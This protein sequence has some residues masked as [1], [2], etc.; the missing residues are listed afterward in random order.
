[1]VSWRGLKL[2][3]NEEAYGWFVPRPDQPDRFDQQASFFHSQS[4]GVAWMVG[5]NGAGTTNISLA[6]MVRFLMETPPPRYDTPFWV[7]SDT[8]EVVCESCWKEKLF[9]QGL[10]PRSEID[11]E[12]IHWYKSTRGWPFAVPL[13]PYRD[14]PNKNWVIEFKSYKQGRS[15]MQARSIGGFLFV[16]QFPWDLLTEVLRGCREYNYPGS[17]LCEFTPINPDLSVHLQEML[18]EDTLPRGWEVFRANTECAMEA[19]HV[20]KEW[21]EEF[22][23][24]IPEETRL[25]RMTG[26]WATYEGQI[27]QGFNRSLNAID[28]DHEMMD[29]FSKNVHHRRGIDWGAGPSNAFCC[30]FGYKNG[31]GQW[32]VYDEYYSTEPVTTIEHLC[33]CQRIAKLYG[34][35]RTSPYYGTAYADPS[36]AD[37]IRI[38][39]DFDKY[40]PVVKD[41]EGHESPEFESLDIMRANNSV[42]R[43]IEHI[44]WLL[45]PD[46]SLAGPD[47]KPQPRLVIHKQRC[48]NLMR[49]M[50]TY[51]WIK[52][53]ENTI[54]PRDPQRDPLKKDDHAVDS[55]R[56]LIFSDANVTGI[57]PESVGIRRDVG[58]LGVHRAADGYRTNGSRRGVLLSKGES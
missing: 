6:K 19:G 23:S 43:G 12:R 53:S 42:H 58:N 50:Q 30:L 45:Q 35:R 2:D 36:G 28:D 44:Q 21:F 15:Q 54:N 56:Y 14:A 13:K 9:E 31:R 41:D 3:R 38:A 51:R 26:A 22:F 16:E 25:T 17:K 40:C 4:P 52:G 7:I 49:Q 11:W 47:G 55:L 20:S 24:M 46:P 1:M 29:P 48:K 27:Y 33:H 32:V 34:W 18:E 39:Q 5:G 57:T 10:L 8:Y 37:Q